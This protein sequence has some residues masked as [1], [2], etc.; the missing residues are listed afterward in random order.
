MI[1]FSIKC[2]SK[3]VRIKFLNHEID[4]LKFFIQNIKIR[5]VSKTLAQ[6]DTLGVLAHKI[7]IEAFEHEIDRKKSKI[8]YYDL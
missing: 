7:A 5:Q 2:L 1:H 6:F 3:K 8:F 4:R